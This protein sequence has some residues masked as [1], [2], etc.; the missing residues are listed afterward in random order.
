MHCCWL[1]V[2][3]IVYKHFDISMHVGS[4]DPTCV[5][6]FRPVPLAVFEILGFKLKKNDNKK[7]KNRRNRLFAISPMLMVQ[8]KPKILVDIH[9]D[10]GYHP[11]VSKVDYD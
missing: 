9:I 8:F 11:A 1:H 6:N 10:L 5:Q 7:K 2:N 3:Y 4:S